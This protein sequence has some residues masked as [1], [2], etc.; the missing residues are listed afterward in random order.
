MKMENK[1]SR[2]KIIAMLMLS[3][4]V[5]TMVG[6]ELTQVS[7]A[8]NNDN[9]SQQMDDRQE[10]SIPDAHLKQVLNEKLGQ[11]K[12]QA[13][14]KAQMETFKELDIHDKSISSIEGLQ[15]CINMTKLV[16]GTK[17]PIGTPGPDVNTI[18][19]LSPLAKMKDKSKLRIIQA[20]HL[21]ISDFSSLEGFNLVY[22]NALS[23]KT[24]LAKQNVVVNQEGSFSQDGGSLT[25]KNPYL[26]DKGKAII[27]TSLDGG[28][29]DE[30]SNTITWS[31]D[32]VMKHKNLTGTRPGTGTRY[33]MEL[34][35]GSQTSPTPNP[36]GTEEFSFFDKSPLKLANDTINSMFSNNKPAWGELLDDVTE[37]QIN[38][39]KT[40][41]QNVKDTDSYVSDDLDPSGNAIIVNKKLVS[42]NFQLADYLF[43]ARND[44]NSLFY[45]KN[46]DSGVL[47]ADVTK[48][49]ISKV[50][51]E[52]NE[53][54]D[55]V[56]KT[57]LLNLVEKAYQLLEATQ[58]NVNV[59]DQT[60]RS[61]LNAKLKQSP[62]HVLTK[63]EL[64]S[65][66]GTLDL[67]HKNITNLDGLQYCKSITGLAAGWNSF[68]NSSLNFIKDLKLTSLNIQSNHNITDLSALKNMTTLTFLG[69][70][71]DQ[72]SSLDCL[73][74][75]PQL[76]ALE[77][78]ANPYS[79]ISALSGM[80]NL[81]V[82]VV[83]HSKTSDLTPLSGLTN[84]TRLWADNMPN[85]TNISPL[86]NLKKLD[87]LH[88]YNDSIKDFS[89]LN[90]LHIRDLEK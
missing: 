39:A 26:D 34:E 77:A 11:D 5:L 65:I 85:V 76:T 9:I 64:A 27:P 58:E 33:E 43:N 78:G 68:D 87:S 10:V 82:L 74:G 32:E 45:Q 75:L 15:Y 8:T 40:L 50:E 24:Y 4:T 62:T 1:M 61:V 42:K 81:S 88:I 29:Y 25:I 23:P 47:G 12:D 63:T 49:A 59:P 86:R 48:E 57:K 17:Y 20:G 3:T 52:V 66:K 60:L 18:S 56:T 30:T 84:L 22:G 16:I 89:P 51:K 2:K 72:V 19:D 90:G 7:A 71:D 79:D 69:F 54:Q 83:A 35:F 46:P 14:T 80:K 41:L 55:S 28:V 36:A 13:I 38:N 70:W 53:L 37:A 21:N 73:A 6:T 44:V 67:N 31:N